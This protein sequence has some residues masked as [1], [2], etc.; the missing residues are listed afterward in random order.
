MR[1]NEA[2]QR[3]KHLFMVSLCLGILIAF[4]DNYL[5]SFF[6]KLVN[7]FGSQDLTSRTLLVYGIGLLAVCLLKY[8]QESPDN[9]LSHRLYLDFKIQALNQI[10]QLK[11]QSYQNL[12]TGLLIQKVETGS[13]A[14]KSIIVDFYLNVLKELVPSMVFSLY[15]IFKINQT[16]TIILLIG[17]IFVF[18]ASRTLLAFL[19]QMKERVLV[20]EERFNS[21]L[22]R[23]FTEMVIFRLTNLFSTE[24]KKL[25]G[26]KQEIVAAKV[27]MNLIHESFFTLFAIFIIVI[28]MIILFYTWKTKSLS[29]GVAIALLS[30]VDNA[31]NP[32]AIFNVLYVQFKL[33]Q[34]AYDRYL[35]MIDLPKDSQ[36]SG[37]YSFPIHQR[38]ITFSNVY[39]SY[40]EHPLIDHF[41]L[42]IECGTSVALIGESG[43]G[44]S[45]ILK[46]M[47]GL[48]QPLDGEIWIG[49]H[50][51]KT[52]DLVD[53]Y[54][55]ITYVSQDSPVF[56]GTL[57]ENIV[58][59]KPIKDEAILQVLKKVKLL[60]W[61]QKLPKGLETA[62]GE[63]GMTLSGGERQR[64]A[65]A[66]LWFNQS[67]IIIL[68]EA[69]SA[70]DMV[71]ENQVMETILNEFGNRTIFT[72]AHRFNAIKDY[73][74]T[75]IFRKGKLIAD[76]KFDTLI[77]SC[78]YLKMLVES[79]K[80]IE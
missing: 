68:D 45:T 64:V 65:L 74:R 9:K 58:F 2:V 13:Q 4:L 37:G 14:G 76:G 59:K 17:Y 39:F 80:F 28:K 32:I 62:I 66:R 56:I 54:Q 69:T 53:Y 41:N 27:K 60:D 24:Q 47:I 20:D 16:I 57:R 55:H 77:T 52:L 12:G 22:I 61:Y 21:I 38:T 40:N 51:L 48:L 50:P 43:S 42:T 63:K 44:K 19:Y 71:T 31:Y 70:M 1:L 5:A 67:E 49:K 26:Y 29:I 72:I 7:Q 10:N 8:S 33:D 36:L 3:N 78:T 30:L 46:L 6:E 79:G 75:L 73:N 35:A 34:L 23:G 18:I 15:F 11:Y 25:E